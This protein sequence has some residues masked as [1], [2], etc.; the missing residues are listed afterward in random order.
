M[1]RK[2][3]FKSYKQTIGGKNNDEFRALT[4]SRLHAAFGELSEEELLLLGEV[5]FSLLIGP[6]VKVYDFVVDF[7]KKHLPEMLQLRQQI[8]VFG[9]QYLEM[10]MTPYINLYDTAWLGAFQW[11]IGKLNRIYKGDYPPVR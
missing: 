2:S 1:S 10:D 7:S 6:G 3:K 8:N 5:W 9:R 11:S 4:Q